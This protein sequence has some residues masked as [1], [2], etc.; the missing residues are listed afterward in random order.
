MSRINK[1]VILAILTLISSAFLLFQLYYYKHYLSAKTL[2]ALLSKITAVGLP[3]WR[4]G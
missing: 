1:N 4:S 2:N 3:W